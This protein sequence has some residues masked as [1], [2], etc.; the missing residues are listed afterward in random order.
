MLPLVLL[1]SMAECYAA[2]PDQADPAMA[3]WFKSLKQPGTGLPCCSIADCHRVAVTRSGGYYYVEIEGQWLRVA[4][5][6]IMQAKHNPVGTVACY[7]VAKFGHP[8]MPGASPDDMHDL[9]E[10]LCLVIGDTTS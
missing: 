6:V 5:A 2:P 7:T 4:N 1:L 3:E 9:L 8:S 10:V